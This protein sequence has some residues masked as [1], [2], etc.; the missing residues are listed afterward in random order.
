[1]IDQ[2]SYQDFDLLMDRG[3]DL[4]AGSIVNPAFAALSL[5]QP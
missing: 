3:H 5:H 1:V 4:D 2:F